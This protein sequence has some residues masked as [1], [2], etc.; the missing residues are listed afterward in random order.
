MGN[1]LKTSKYRELFKKL[2]ELGWK[3]G[4]LLNLCSIFNPTCQCIGIGDFLFTLYSLMDF[5]SRNQVT[6]LK[7]TG[8]NH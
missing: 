1:K 5:V 8:K 7:I 3:L 4:L 2:E 6:G